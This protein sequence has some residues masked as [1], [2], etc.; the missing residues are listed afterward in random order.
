[1][2]LAQRLWG[3]VFGKKAKII[4]QNHDLNIE[5]KK[6]YNFIQKEVTKKLNPQKQLRLLF[7]CS[8]QEDFRVCFYEVYTLNNQSKYTIYQIR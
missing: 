3:E 8:N 4:L 1:M 5:C 6:Y 7:A 2:E